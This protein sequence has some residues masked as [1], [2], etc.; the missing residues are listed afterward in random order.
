MR[1][2]GGLQL[3]PLKV[4]LSLLPETASLRNE[5]NFGLWLTWKIQE[6]ATSKADWFKLEGLWC[7]FK[8]HFF[9]PWEVSNI[10]DQLSW[11]EW[12]RLFYAQVSRPEATFMPLFATFPLLLHLPFVCFCLSLCSWHHHHNP[13]CLRRQGYSTPLSPPPRFAFPPAPFFHHNFFMW[14]FHSPART[15]GALVFSSSIFLL[16]LV[17]QW[18]CCSCSKIE[19]VCHNIVHRVGWG[20]WQ[21]STWQHDNQDPN[22]WLHFYNTVQDHEHQC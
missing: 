22:V 2:E 13:H 21:A 18:L 4:S 16:N 7:L 14:T 8:R 6:H 9:V 1:W 5:G 12:V 17:S 20:F 11:L 10:L 3:A 19:K 15:Q